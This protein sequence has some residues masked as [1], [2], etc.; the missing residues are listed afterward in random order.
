MKIATFN[1]WNSERGM[2]YREQQII[3]EITKINSDI[4]CLQE[5]TQK[6]FIKLENEL[7]VYEHS[8]YHNFNNE[9]EGLA[10]FSKFPIILKNDI[11]CAVLVT[12]EYKDN[13]FLAANVHLPWDSIIKKEKYILDIVK[14]IDKIECDYTFLMGDFNCSDNSSVHYFLTGEMSLHGSEAKPIFEDMA[15]VY[16]QLSNTIPEN[17]LDLINNPRWKGKNT[18]SQSERFDRIYLRD[19]FPKPFPALNSFCLFGKEI[20]K[21][22]AYCSSDHYGVLTEILFD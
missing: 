14:E 22:S 21:H 20:D 2:P 12:F 17:T 16:S 1:I 13:I 18:A 9:Y 11:N 15:Q 6:A 8:Y 10:V 4:I 19:A 3:N 7:S 5:V